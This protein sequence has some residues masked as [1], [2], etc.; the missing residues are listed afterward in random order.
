M[1]MPICK[2]ITVSTGVKC[3]NKTRYFGYCGIHE[4]LHTGENPYDKIPR[5]AREVNRPSIKQIQFKSNK[6]PINTNKNRNNKF[7][8]NR[9]NEYDY[10]DG[11]LVKDEPEQSDVDDYSRIVDSEYKQVEECLYIL[12]LQDNKYYVGRTT[13]LTRLISEHINGIGSEWTKLYHPVGTPIQLPLTGSFG[14]ED[15][16]VKELMTKYGIN[17]V[18]GGSYSQINLSTSQLSVLRAEIASHTNNCFKCGK[19]GHYSRDCEDELE[20]KYDDE[21]YE[22]EELEHK[23]DEP[24]DFIVSKVLELDYKTNQALVKW[25]S[26]LF[27]KSTLDKYRDEV[28]E[29]KKINS[30]E[31]YIK[32]KNGWI[33]LTD[34]L[35]KMYIANLELEADFYD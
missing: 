28:K 24:E 20:H 19:S 18:R 29:C 2:A 3:S 26:G 22:Q 16:K 6:K 32:W 5:K 7:K 25:T 21:K 12:S 23:Y 14:E 27:D 30:N 4:Y 34:D 17:N 35:E 1:N 8:S 10:N 31:Y 13:D 15:Q 9:I 33:T 11:F